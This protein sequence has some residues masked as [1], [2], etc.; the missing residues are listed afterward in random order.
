MAS[1]DRRLSRICRTPRPEAGADREPRREVALDGYAALD[2]GTTFGVCATNLSYGGCEVETELAL[3]PGLRL[4]ISMLGLGN[5]VGATVRWCRN[6]RAGL[7]F[8]RAEPGAAA[9]TRRKDERLPVAAE[10]SLRRSGSHHYRVRLFDLTPSGCKVEFV[11]RPRAGETLWIR[12]VALDSI[13]ARVR[14]VEGF[15]GGL[16]FTTPI[17]PAVFD[18]LLVKLR[19]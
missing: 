19:A 2:D 16:E 9:R 12:F 5:A 17:H 1:D 3:L 7:E 13:E 11:E 18:M 15:V 10:V 14:W 4:K 6:G 8:D